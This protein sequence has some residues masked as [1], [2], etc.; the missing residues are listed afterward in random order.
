MI[1][2]H[3]LQLF[4]LITLG[5]II[6][7]VLIGGPFVLAHSINER[8]PRLGSLSGGSAVLWFFTYPLIGWGLIEAGKALI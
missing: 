5:A 2:W 7:P 8:W 4:G 3:I 6:G 1:A